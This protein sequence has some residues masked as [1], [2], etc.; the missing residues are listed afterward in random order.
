MPNKT[1]F[2]EAIIIT[3]ITSG[4]FYLFSTFSI[5]IDFLDPIE[6][7]ISDIE[8]TDLYFSIFLDERNSVDTNIVLI[9]FGELE[10]NDIA[11]VVAEINKY[12]P[13]VIGIDAFFNPQTK[14]EA[15]SSITGTFSK[16]NNL[17]LVSILRGDINSN[18]NKNK[19][20]FLMPAYYQK[21]KVGYANLKEDGAFRTI[22]SFRPLVNI[23]GKDY[24]SFGAE[25]CRNYSQNSIKKLLARNCPEEVINFKGNQH[26]FYNLSAKDILDNKQ[27]L[28][29][30]NDKIVILGF[31][32][33]EDNGFSHRDFED[34]FFTPLNKKYVGRGDPDMFGAVIHANI[35]SMIL[36]E[37]YINNLS[38]VLKYLLFSF[39][40]FINSFIFLLLYQTYHHSYSSIS[41]VVIILESIILL[42]ISFI[43]LHNFNL[44]IELKPIL[45]GIV[46]LPDLLETYKGILLKIKEKK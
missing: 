38:D 16:V 1:N 10:R 23:D 4:I 24:L 19:S 44:K 9:N 13:K 12:N 34:K 15:D 3:I 26:N 42:F 39:I 11:K 18:S 17:V 36:K 35:I 22:R 43:V 40:I 32:G 46:F 14:V 37:D 20:Y 27:K 28:F 29:F 45:I 7:T 8:L 6:N 2:I 25:I 30:L 31:L 41:K 33:R 21:A 5:N